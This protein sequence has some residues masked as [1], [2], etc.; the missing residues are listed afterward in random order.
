MDKWRTKWATAKRDIAFKLFR[1]ECGG[2]YD[3][4]VL[5]LCAALSALA[6]EV[7]P[8][9]GID[10][11]RFIQLLNEFT[12]VELLTLKISVPSLVAALRTQNRI[13]EMQQIQ[14]AYLN[15]PPALVLIGDNYDKTEE[16]IFS[17]CPNLNTAEVREYNYASLLYRNLRSGYTHNYR[18]RGKT[19]IWAMTRDQN[20]R[21]SYVNWIGDPD[22]HIHFH[23]TWLSDL[24]LICA[25]ALDEI[26]DQ[27]PHQLP[28]R[29]WI[30][31]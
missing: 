11:K 29:W 5:I 8:G 30:D 22:R 13:A 9:I 19:D 26:S 23:I 21:V 27:L 3:E 10:R 6:G 25:K 24:V 15:Y 28:S 17:V 14:K 31:G 7:W 2:S 12:P 18:P 20:A 4:A 1:G 16:E